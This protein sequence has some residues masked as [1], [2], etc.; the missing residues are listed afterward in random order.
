MG[1]EQVLVFAL[2]TPSSLPH[3]G[4]MDVLQRDDE[5]RVALLCEYLDRL[6][7]GPVSKEIFEG[8]R[9]AAEST[10]PFEVN[11]ALEHLLG[12]AVDIAA[13]EVPVARFIRS[14]GKALEGQELP[15]Y[16][17]GSL[18]ARLDQ[19]NEAIASYLGDQQEL[20]KRLQRETGL[21]L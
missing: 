14:V 21:P 16:P 18:F 3:T 8:Y 4:G 10:T 20:N 7:E 5:G 15:I 13:C 1:G 6:V 9:A 19:E 11:R 2:D 17:E 12:A